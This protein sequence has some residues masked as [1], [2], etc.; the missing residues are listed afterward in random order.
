MTTSL[1]L[2][3]G[4]CLMVVNTVG[5]NRRNQR[6]KSK[7]SRERDANKKGDIGQVERRS[8]RMNLLSKIHFLLS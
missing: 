5:L 3:G 2:P 7:F 1:D 6:G 4:R 8:S